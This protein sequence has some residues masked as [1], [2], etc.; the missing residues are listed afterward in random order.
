MSL[1]DYE[2][3]FSKL[4][5]NRSGGR[6]SPHKVALLLAVLEM[7]DEKVIIKNEIVLSDELK[8]VFTQHFKS[9]ASGSDRNNPYLPFFHLRS[10]GF[11]HHKIKLGRRHDYAQLESVSSA[12][13]ITRN[14][15][16]AYFD[17]ALFEL[18]NNVVVRKLMKATLLENMEI[19]TDRRRT[20]LDV[21]EEWNWLECEASVQ[22]YFAMLFKQLRG[23]MVNER[24]YIKTLL[25]KTN[26]RS[27]AQIR[28]QYQH[29]S[30]I[31]LEFGQ[32]YIIGFK[33]SFKYQTQLKETVMAHLAANQNDL[34]SLGQQPKKSKPIMTDWKYVLDTEVPEKITLVAEPDLQRKYL[35]RKLNFS[36]KEA[37]N[38]QLGKSGEQF[39]IDFE[40]Y[41]LKQAGRKDLAD[42]VE[43]SSQ[44]RGDG[45]GYDVRSFAWENNQPIE[46][47]HFIEVK[48]TNSGK[49]QPFYISA[50][51]VAFSKDKQEQYSLYRIFNFNKEAQLFQM[52]GAINQHVNL[53]AIQF[54][55]SF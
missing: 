54:K 4:N 14:I 24:D 34:E 7:L 21:G 38:R 9:M 2:S 33:P 47:E 25:G 22:G 27:E 32:P 42:E 18:L 23:E 52:A 31:L 30:A 3:K 35:A 37:K 51:E 12:A 15:S 17:D 48:T 10:S 16:F 40:Q 50:N 6:P 1:L 13:A 49:Y 5:V 39:V 28:I 43:W 44:E 20:L 26:N 46:E 53:S 11:W 55:A 45:L 29:I 8:S 41:K 19:N 36:Q